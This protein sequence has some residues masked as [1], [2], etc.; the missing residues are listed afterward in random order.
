VFHKN[1]TPLHV[2]SN[3]SL[4]WTISIKVT[5]SCSSDNWLTWCDTF[6]CSSY[7]YSLQ[8]M[9]DWVRF[10][11]PPNTELVQVLR[12]CVYGVIRSILSINCRRL[13]MSFD[14]ARCVNISGL[15][16]N[17]LGIELRWVR[18]ILAC[19]AYCII[20]YLGYWRPPLWIVDISCSCLHCWTVNQSLLGDESRELCSMTWLDLASYSLN[21]L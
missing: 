12:C 14:A 8:I 20:W 3:F 21:C 17:L 16:L 13:P 11:I 4:Y 1:R 2:C 5:P 18:L 19:T 9:I 15:L 6:T 7:R 10:N